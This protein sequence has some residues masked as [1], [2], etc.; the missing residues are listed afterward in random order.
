MPVQGGDAMQVT[1]NGGFE[2]FESVDGR[3][4]FYIKSGAGP[5]L[6]SVSV[7][8]GEEK[9]ILD[10]VSHSY[11]GVADHGIYFV[12]F[13]EASSPDA[14]ELIK[15]FEP[16][17]RRITVLGTIRKP[18][19]RPVPGFCVGWDGRQI[20]WAQIDR[21]ESDLMMIENFR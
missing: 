13:L 4:L 2:A 1:K 11:W 8:G 12:D 15:L 17:T 21:L 18:V 14:P 20:L 3:T 10:S 9:L 6:W 19:E 16:D 7:A 5:G